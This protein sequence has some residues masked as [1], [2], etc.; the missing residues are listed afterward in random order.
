MKTKVEAWAYG[1]IF[2]VTIIKW[3]PQL[4]YASLGMSL[5]LEW[6]YLQRTVT[7]VST[8]MGPIEE[9]LRETFFPVIFG[10]EEVN[11]DLGKYYAIVLS[12]EA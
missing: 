3:H 12:M 11:A 5:Q 2:L 1:I 10:G 9:A 6:Q 8:L 4:A 7:R